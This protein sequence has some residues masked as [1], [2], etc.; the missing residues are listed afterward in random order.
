MAA[1]QPAPEEPRQRAGKRAPQGG[2]GDGEKVERLATDAYNDYADA[3]RDAMV[4][5]DPAEG[6]PDALE[7]YLDRLREDLGRERVAGRYADGMRSYLRLARAYLDPKQ[8]NS[9]AYRTYVDELAEQWKTDTASVGTDAY[10]AYLDAVGDAL[11]PEELERRA[12][13]AWSAY[14]RKLQEAVAALGR[15]SGDPAEIAAIAYSAA[16]AGTLRKMASDAVLSRH[17]ARAN[18]AAVRPR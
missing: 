18:V 10:G 14:A 2:G 8:S 4:A 17:A 11:D 13:E 6:M 9:E 1:E 7:Q 15:S 16:A 5:A 3:L 12:D